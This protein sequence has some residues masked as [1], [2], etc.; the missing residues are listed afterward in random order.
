MFVTH[1]KHMLMRMA[2]G[3][4]QEQRARVCH[5]ESACLQYNHT[6]LCKCSLTLETSGPNSRASTWKTCPPAS[7]DTDSTPPA[8]CALPNCTIAQHAAYIG[9]QHAHELHGSSASRFRA[10][11]LPQQERGHVGDPSG[12]TRET[13]PAGGSSAPAVRGHDST[14]WM[15]RGKT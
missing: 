14:A 7:R 13:A 5:D 3:H 6:P 9:T 11:N 4:C 2:L 10:S 15:D 12:P 1:E 8:L